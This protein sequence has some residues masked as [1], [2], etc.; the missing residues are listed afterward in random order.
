MVD[1][2]SD[3]M[4]RKHIIFFMVLL[5]FLLPLAPA[6]AS[7]I[8]QEVSFFQIEPLPEFIPF[9]AFGGQELM[10]HPAIH[11]FIGH[12]E[13]FEALGNTL[14]R[15]PVGENYKIRFLSD[16]TTYVFAPMDC[17]LSQIE[18]G[19]WLDVPLPDNASGREAAAQL[20]IFFGEWDFEN[21]PTSRHIQVYPFQ[22]IDQKVPH[23][24]FSFDF[25]AGIYGRTSGFYANLYSTE[26]D[27]INHLKEYGGLRHGCWVIFYAGKG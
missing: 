11:F 13:E 15:L 1:F 22:S 6:F 23:I 4:L 18:G 7:G 19:N 8:A 10:D 26:E 2:S 16:E 24:S 5:M 17:T 14:M 25:P 9:E 12:L 20:D 27:A 21:Y 3:S